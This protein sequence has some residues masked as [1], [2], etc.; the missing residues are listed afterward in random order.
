MPTVYKVHGISARYFCRRFSYEGQSAKCTKSRQRAMTVWRA[1][2]LVWQNYNKKLS[3]RA[4][5][6]IIEYFAKSLK[7]IGN[8]ITGKL[9]YGFTFAFHMTLSC[10]ISKINLDIGENSRFF[11]SPAFEALVRVSRSP[12]EY[13]HNVWYSKTR[14]VC[15]MFSRLHII[16]AC[17]GQTD[18]QT[19]RQTDGR[20]DRTPCN[21]TDRAVK[22]A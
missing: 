8:G 1:N 18:R 9:G 5:L 21:S 13:C 20:T 6:R 10:I 7:V 16:A 2:C 12:S 3:S 17:D 19:D 4:I 22:T 14:M 11:K 15:L